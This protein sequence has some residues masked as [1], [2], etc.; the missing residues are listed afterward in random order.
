MSA[1]DIKT[2]IKLVH[3]RKSERIYILNVYLL[4]DEFIKFGR[5]FRRMIFCC[6]CF[7][8]IW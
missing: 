5:I 3:S 7:R 8:H 4:K 1:K 6:C 2:C